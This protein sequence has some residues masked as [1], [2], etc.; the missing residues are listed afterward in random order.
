MVLPCLTPCVRYNSSVYLPLMRNLMQS[1]VYI[2]CIKL[3][4]FPP[5]P[6]LASFANKA[7]RQTLSYAWILLIVLTWF[8]QRLQPCLCLW[9]RQQTVSACSLLSSSE[10][11]EQRLHPECYGRVETQTALVPTSGF[12][13]LL[14]SYDYSFSQ[15]WGGAGLMELLLGDNLRVVVSL[16]PAKRIFIMLIH[17]CRIYLMD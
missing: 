6:S 14:C 1:L 16:H 11:R 7:G 12:L 5:K 2:D 9:K 15:L 17:I 10:L 8:L 13:L 3:K 4:V